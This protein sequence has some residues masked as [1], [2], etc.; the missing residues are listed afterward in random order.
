MGT[1]KITILFNERVMMAIT[2]EV[3]RMILCY[4]PKASE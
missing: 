2:H 1:T 4:E 3:M